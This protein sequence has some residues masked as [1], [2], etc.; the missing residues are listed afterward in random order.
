MMILQNQY[1]HVK[2]EEAHMNID[3]LKNKIKCSHILDP[4]NLLQQSFYKVLLI[5]V[6]LQDKNLQIALIGDGY[7]VS[8]QCAVLEDTVLTVLQNDMIVQLDVTNGS[9]VKHKDLEWF[10]CNFELHKLE[11]DYLIY[12]EECIVRLDHELKE[13][14]RFSGKDIF[15]SASGKQSFEL[16]HDSIKLYDFQDNFYELDFSGQLIAMSDI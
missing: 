5:T 6:V 12:G 3:C 8:K 13:K 1:F 11:N 7:S 14:W 2:V 9:L 10:G 4:K 15:V 16:G